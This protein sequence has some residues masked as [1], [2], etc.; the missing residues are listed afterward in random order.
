MEESALFA[1]AVAGFAFAIVSRRIEA[2]PLSAPIVFTGTGIA[3]GPL[4][5][6][7]I[8][9]S[10]G[11]LLEVVATATLALVL[12]ADA[13]SIKFQSA[14]R[15]N[16]MRRVTTRL[17]GLALPLTILAGAVVGKLVFPDLAWAEAFVL[18]L[19]LA[20]TDAALSQPVFSAK[21]LPGP[22]QNALDAESGLNDGICLPLLLLALAISVE[23]FDML[24]GSAWGRVFLGQLV[25]APVYGGA[26]G[27]IGA[28][29]IATCRSRHEIG[30]TWHSLSI[31]ALAGIAFIGSELF[32]GNGFL[33]AWTAGLVFGL[34]SDDEA[35]EP[36]T[37]FVAAE[38]QLLIQA[39]FV[40]FGAMIVPQIMDPGAALYLLYG[41]LTLT[42]MRM[43]PVALV[44]AGLG[45][46]G[47][48]KTF[49]G[50]FGPRGIASILYLVLVVDQEGF[51]AAGR[52]TDIAAMTILLSILLHGVTATWGVA[53]YRRWL[54]KSGREY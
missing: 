21:G 44:L 40:L 6:G 23:G 28:R 8:D 11:A 52:I 47:T 30:E 25:L 53:V 43:V 51:T 9:V 49:I 26:I 39:S 36:L 33:S 46:A 34:N 32:G 10:G 29:L 7:L 19:V 24:S 14:E 45:L 12:F 18:A 22:V 38:G 1:V 17:L 42:V 37:R 15:R 13:A 27:F 35:S 2:G 16:L 20:P 3:I 48:S 54:A 4:G 5:L 41:I 50:W 31:L